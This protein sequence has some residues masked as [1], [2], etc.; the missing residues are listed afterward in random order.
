MEVF[1]YP[2]SNKISGDSVHGL[3]TDIPAIEKCRVVEGDSSGI[4]DLDKV[5]KCSSALIGLLSGYPFSTNNSTLRVLTSGYH[6]LSC[7]WLLVNVIVSLSIAWDAAQD[8]I[9]HNLFLKLTTIAWFTQVAVCSVATFINCQQKSKLQAYY[10]QLSEVE[11]RLSL[12][13]V[14][15]RIQRIRKASA[16]ATAFGWIY[17]LVNIGTKVYD[18]VTIRQ[19]DLIYGNALKQRLRSNT[20]FEVLQLFG[21]I[22]SSLAVA[23]WILT[24][25]YFFATSFTLLTLL[26]DF[27]RKLGKDASL[28]PGEVLNRIHQY[29]VTHLELCNLVSTVESSFSP[30]IGFITGGNV[31]LLLLVFYLISLVASDPVSSSWLFT[32]VTWT[33]ATAGLLT[34]YITM[35]EKVCSEV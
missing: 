22:S 31:V 34:L 11:K 24:A 25:A 9:L 12:L 17:I 13:G 26:S 5:I 20:P 7:L 1:K 8:A 14:D 19:Q 28:S 32:Y 27:N 2:R 16:S 3:G 29:R 30:I 4:R 10:E 15:I 6:A 23:H 35:A 33:V 18:Y 21:I